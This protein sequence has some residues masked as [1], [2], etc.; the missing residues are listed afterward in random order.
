MA[1]E[2]FTDRKE[3]VE[4]VLPVAV[5][6]LNLVMIRPIQSPVDMVAL[7]ASCLAIGMTHEMNDG[8]LYCPGVADLDH[9]ERDLMEKVDAEW[10]HPRIQFD[11]FKDT[12][13]QR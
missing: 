11:D 13:H 10:Y 5:H 12:C 1:K 6:V 9:L 3:R 7:A 4:T 8:F 2:L